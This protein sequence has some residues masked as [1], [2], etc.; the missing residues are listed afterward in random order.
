MLREGFETVLF[1]AA[2]FQQGLVPALGATAGIL[3]AIAVGFLLFRWG[4]KI[5]LRAFFL[6]M[7]IFLLLI[8]A[9]LVVSALGHID[10]AVS[11]LAQIDRQSE[12]LCFY[13][14]RFTK[15]PSCILGPM[16]WNTSRVLPESQFPGVILH[17]LFGYED[18]L[19]VV[20][21]VGY[22]LF[23]LVIGG[24]YLKS[25]MGWKL[26]SAKAISTETSVGK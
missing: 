10:T 23:L 2:K 7:G 8:V 16:V 15:F 4:V 12:S 9:G 3:S 14:E 26:P 18:K 1:I 17:T 21:V 19:Y 25:V 22:V 20:Q 6:V 5:N 11:T 24:V 13:Y